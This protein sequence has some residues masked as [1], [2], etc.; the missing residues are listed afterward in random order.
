MAGRKERIETTAAPASTGFRSQGLIAGGLFFAAGQ[1]GAEMQRGGIV[2]EPSTDMGEA[3]SITLGHLEQVTL[4]AD[5]DRRNVFE[6]SAFPKETGS[7]ER[8]YQEVV[9]Y[10]GFEPALFNYHE[11]QD[12]AMHAMI[13]M[14]WMAVAEPSLTVQEAAEW[15]RPLGSGLSNETISRGPFSIWNGLAGHGDNLAEASRA[16][17]GDLKARLEAQGGELN[18]LVKL[19]VHL[20]A[21]EPYPMFNEVTKEYFQKIIPPVRSVLVDPALTG[22]AKIVIDVLALKPQ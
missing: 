9:R 8:I 15:L 12:V 22:S 14:D 4:A 7:R 5:L 3:V 17:L 1:I 2:R 10:L 13:E 6:V 20:D 18:D 19:T 21:F 11:V 16:V